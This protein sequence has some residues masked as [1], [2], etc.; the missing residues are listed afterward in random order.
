[1]IYL[2]T[3]VLLADV[4]AE[5]T[6]PHPALFDQALVSSRLLLYE[7]R[8]RLNALGAS[9]QT[10][11]AADERLAKVS[12]VEMASIVLMR[13]LDPFPVLVRTL[14]ALH[15]STLMHL[16]TRGQRVIL[17]TYDT[18]MRAAAAA[19]DVPSVDPSDPPRRETR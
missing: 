15:L 16:R 4:L 17:C 8:T 1:M 6:R 19:L 12:M 3:S 5:E 7:T 9:E 13:A 10:N 14:D 11:A 18:R 2:D